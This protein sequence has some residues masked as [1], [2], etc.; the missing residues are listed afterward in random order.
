MKEQSLAMTAHLPSPGPALAWTASTVV[1]ALL[2]GCGGSGAPPSTGTQEG[3]VA[4][5]ASCYD[6]TTDNLIGS[7]D[8]FAANTWALK[9]TGP[10]QVVSAVANQGMAGIDANVEPVHKA[11][12]GCTGKGVT[13]A[14]IDVGLEAT[15]EDLAPNVIPGKSWNF[16]TNT[17]NPNPA[18]EQ[19]SI[20]HGTGVAGIVAAKG[21]NGKGSRGIAPN[22]GLLGFA[23]PAS[24]GA[25]S[26]TSTEPSPTPEY[27]RFGA[28]ILADAKDAIVSLFGDRADGVQ[29]FNFSVGSDIAAPV[30]IEDNNPQEEAARW[31]TSNLRAGRGALYFQAAGNEFG[32]MNNGS[33]PDGTNYEGLIS[34]RGMLITEK[35]AQIGGTL[36]RYDGV[37]CGNANQDPYLKPYFFQVASLNNTGVASSYST[38]GAANWISGFGGEFGEDEAAMITTDNSGCKS[39]DNNAAGKASLLERLSNSVDKLRRLIADLFGEDSAK[40]PQCNYTGRF[41]GTSAATPSVAGVAALMLEANPKLT[42]QDVGY[43]LAKTARKI[44]ATA[45]SGKQAVTFRPTGGAK[46]WVLDDP[47]ITNQAGFNFQSRYGFGMVDADA[48]ARLATRYAPPSGRRSVNFEATGPSSSS[49]VEDSVVGVHASTVDFSQSGTTGPIRVEFELSNNTDKNINPGQLHFVLTHTSTGTR[50][51]LMPAFTAWY[52]GG[53]LFPIVKGGKQKFRMHTNA[54]F[55]ES[56]AGGYKLE[57]I[58]FSGASGTA[59]KTLS[60][61]PKLTSFSQ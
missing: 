10:D 4:A 1:C 6:G 5:I 49:A 19:A 35:L 25:S 2:A 23:E 28:R 18:A 12:K 21:W 51:I 43:I 11:G 29:I 46:D 40:D 15:H 37:S 13:V 7:D 27:L 34:C 47:W 42:W 31:G 52:F 9:N 53:Q 26:A 55:G 59:G 14:I 58:D 32:A 39:G 33:L 45:S 8:P 54:F 57:V 60:F 56:L 38:G 48:A 3:A 22:A 16:A 44:D 30:P 24:K 50:S 61:T 20:D 36:S 17:D 41:N